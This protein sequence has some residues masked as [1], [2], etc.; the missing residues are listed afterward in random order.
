MENSNFPFPL[1]S[2]LFF[3]LH[4]LFFQEDDKRKITAR[5]LRNGVFIWR[6]G[7][8]FTVDGVISGTIPSSSEEGTSRSELACL[9]AIHK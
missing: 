3:G 8:C 6:L 1:P 4:L 2:H 9:L 7:I 5:I